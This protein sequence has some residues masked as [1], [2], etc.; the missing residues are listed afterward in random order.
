MEMP[1]DS[2]AGE[3]HEA[4]VPTVG[5][6]ETYEGMG[7][8]SARVELGDLVSLLE[9]DGRDSS[10]GGTGATE[11]PDSSKKDSDETQVATGSEGEDPM[12]VFVKMHNR[13]DCVMLQADGFY[14]VEDLKVAAQYAI[15]GEG[16]RLKRGWFRLR[17]PGMDYLEEEVTLQQ[18]RVANLAILETV[19]GI[20]GG[21]QRGRGPR[22]CP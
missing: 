1:T 8:M 21:W 16:V 22:R 11:D 18:A 14:L 20:K 6:H 13:E 2:D 9:K 4:V 5:F 15:R 3:V 10:R 17:R 7:M 19:T 12:Q